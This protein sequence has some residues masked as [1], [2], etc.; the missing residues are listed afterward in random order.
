M[1]LKC[2]KLNCKYNNGFACQAKNIAIKRELSCGTFKLDPDKRVRDTSICMFDEA[3]TYSKHREKKN[4]KV[5]CSATCLFNEQG[6]CNANGLTVNV[7]DEC[8]YCIT[9]VKP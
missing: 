7:I 5:V 4:M 2:R 6:F 1:D 9:Y 8:P 3:P